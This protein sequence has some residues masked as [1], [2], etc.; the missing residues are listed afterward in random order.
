MKIKSNVLDFWSISW[1]ALGVVVFLL[2]WC[3]WYYSIPLVAL[4]VYSIYR[5]YRENG[6][7]DVVSISNRRF[8]E[9]LHIA[10]AIMVLCGIGGYVV[11][12]NDHYWRN[13]MFRDLVNYSWP[14]FDEE[15]GLTKSYYIAFWM[16]PATIAKVFRS[17]EL[18][19]LSQLIW[20][21]IGFHLLFLQI[22]R[23]MGKVRL[24]YFLFF[25]LF[26]G[27]KILECLLFLPVFGEGI[28]ISSMVNI[29]ATNASPG[30]FHAG[31]IAQFLYDPFN[32]TIPLFLGMMVIINDARKAHIPLVFSLLLLYAPF[33][34]VGLAPM[35]LYW[36]F[37]SNKITLWEGVRNL[38]C[39][40]NIAA[41]LILAISAAYL[42]S[43]ENSGHKGLRPIFNLMADVYAYI[44][45]VI[46]EFG[47]LMAVGYKACKDK[48]A[49][50]IAF[51]SVC[52]FAWFQIGLH[53]DFCFRT[54]MPLI[55]MLCLL[56][57]K[58][59]YMTETGMGIKTLIICWYIF[60]GIPAQIHPGLRWLS[61]Y[62]ILQGKPQEELNNYQHFKDVREM[63]V[64]R[65][66]K[67]RNDELPSSF[68]CRPEWNQFRTDVGSPDSFF[69]K[70]MF[71]KLTC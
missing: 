37:K 28:V 64:M 31:P 66:T 10:F 8:W 20:I 30:N 36:F 6:S 45:Y 71:Y 7:T 29:L 70:G 48:V 47:I 5:L 19:F 9:S 3:R 56:V 60:G 27:L 69:F 18:G 41:L 63:Y 23:Y 53:N 14:V 49:L 51:F 1:I 44:L 46:F 57:T 67:L 34:L 32:Q 43:N 38:L 42:M 39:V 40:E 62:Y 59:Y 24:S 52:I 61:S 4:S 58:R 17:V 35:A 21:S 54:N 2:G 15:T 13:A 55:F 33:P 26:S 11:Q 25:Y 68:R 50:W 16:V 12:S 65:Q 22:C